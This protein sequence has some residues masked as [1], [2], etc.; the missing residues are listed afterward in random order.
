MTLR[1]T[2]KG[3]ALAAYLQQQNSERSI[4]ND[5]SSQSVNK[6][7]QRDSSTCPC[8]CS[9]GA[10]HRNVRR[11]MSQGFSPWRP[12][13]KARLTKTQNPCNC[14]GFSFV[15]IEEKRW[16]LIYQSCT[17]STLAARRKKKFFRDADHQGDIS[18][19]RVKHYSIKH[20]GLF[21]A[22]GRMLK[23]KWV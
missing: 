14:R 22:S 7:S 23:S 18:F 11:H 20:S 1:H 19:F 8:D 16:N 10:E 6:N 4:F 5:F 3:S 15:G 21:A 17:C 13:T 9:A 12:T 2:I